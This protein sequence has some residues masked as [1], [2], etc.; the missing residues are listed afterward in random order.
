MRYV[1]KI[2]VVEDSPEVRANIVDI[3]DANDHKVIEAEDGREA[4]SIIREELPDLIVSDIMMPDMDG[5][6]LNAELKKDSFTSAIPFIFLT[7]KSSYDDMRKGMREG[8]DD[9]LT[10]PFKSHDLLE[11]VESKI[12]KYNQIEERMNELRKNISM[13][14]PHEMRTP[15]VSILGYAGFLKEERDELDLQERCEM[16]DNI[17]NSAHRLNDIVQKFLDYSEISVIESD[18]KELERIRES[19]TEDVKVILKR[20]VCEIAKSFKRINDLEFDIQESSIKIDETHLTTIIKELSEN[21]FKF[22]G[23]D[24]K[25]EVKSLV[26]KDYYVIRIKNNGKGL[27]PEQIVNLNGFVQFE[28]DNSQKAG[29]GIGLMIVK[30]LLDLYKGE[31]RIDSEPGQ[32]TTVEVKLPLK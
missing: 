23:R 1:L 16:I 24:S 30:K 17:N 25:V 10:K 15:L 6:E 5:Y 8:A 3:L 29:N 31:F 11:A 4:L 12:R 14:V 32:Y 13:Y 2:L 7:A 9:F 22:S 21:A 18:K 26:E 19:Y 20:K 27:T 28:R